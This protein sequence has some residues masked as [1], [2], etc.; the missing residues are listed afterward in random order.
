[1]QTF[2][3][4]VYFSSTFFKLNIPTFTS[5]CFCLVVSN[6][7]SFCLSRTT[8]KRQNMSAGCVWPDSSSIRSTRV[9]C[10]CCS[11]SAPVPVAVFLNVSSLLLLFV[12]TSCLS[13][14][15]LSSESSVP[16][17]L[18]RAPRSPFSLYPFLVFQCSLAHL[19]LQIR[20]EPHCHPLPV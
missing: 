1:M 4:Y 7:L 15:P 8:W 19:C 12:V 17:C 13:T 10:K 20:G 14:S 18:L 3:E 16:P 2:R 5:V 6:T 11:I 9:T